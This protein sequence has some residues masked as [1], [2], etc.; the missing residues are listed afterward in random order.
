MTDS[1][2]LT[3]SL[4]GNP[5]TAGSIVLIGNSNVG[6]TTIFRKLCNKN[7]QIENLPDSFVEL[8]IGKLDLNDRLYKVIDI[9]GITSLFGYSEEE[10][11]ARNLIFS[12]ENVLI[13]QV[14][15]A[16]NL[17]RDLTLSC[18]LVELGKPM[19]L[20]LNMMDE[21][22]QKGIIID[23]KA[24]GDSLGID[25]VMTIGN[26]G[27]GIDEVKKSLID[28]RVSKI[29]NSYPA[30][31]EN[32]IEEI[33]SLPHRNGF[34]NRAFVL[35]LLVKESSIREYIESTFLDSH[36]M[37]RANQIVAQVNKGSNQDLQFS[38]VQR[39]VERAIEIENSCIKS[40]PVQTTSFG[41][42][43]SN[44][45]CHPV[46]GAPILLAVIGIL[47]LFVGKL[48]AG[49]F[50]D[51]IQFQIFGHYV[52]PF[53]EK[54]L[55]NI[56]S[57]LIQDAFLGTYGLISMGLTAGLG[58]VFPIICTFFFSYSILEDS[59]YL[60]R[61]GILLDSVFKRIGLNGKAVLPL[62]LGFSCVTMATLSAR[63]LDTKKERIIAIL[64]LWLCVPCSAQ[65]S[66][67]AAILASISLKAVLVIIG[68]VAIQL[69]IV[70]FTAGKL[71]PGEKPIFLM[72]IHPIRMPNIRFTLYKT[73]LKVKR[74]FREVIP[75]FLVASLVLFILDKTKVL[76][77]IEKAGEPVVTG[78]LGLP[79]KITEVFMLGLIRR[80]AGA[81]F[82]KTIAD[83]ERLSE[84]QII[85]AMVV[86]TLFVPCVTSIL[87][88]VKE[89]SLKIA[90]GISAFVI[91]YALL[92]G[93][94][95]NKLLH[96][97][98]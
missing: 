4:V 51:F 7:I 39:R 27:E 71:I 66:I 26:E 53:V 3:I 31:I 59:G 63:A 92:V 17:R 13:L 67:F 60:S 55:S 49:I 74:F 72:E 45:A 33:Q 11:I 78:L 40:L 70:G 57:R 83:A 81:A 46:Y 24:I 54:A 87:V 96:L 8:S 48:G 58:V 21:A 73:V 75:L 28:P 35:Q 10:L 84:I 95:L 69:L 90:G 1:Q 65:L 2:L 19:V 23:E 52:I 25:A 34:L 86:M 38:I 85:V 32:G 56:P 62:F 64:L 80:E 94:I 89:Y 47:Y 36:E 88:V 9:P 16:K 68:V 6:K 42:K 15:D 98:Y 44:C 43:F 37:E 91:G 79:P 22:L 50:A 5:E 77:F 14:A 97:F 93:I 61:I 82:F 76:H 29:R 30:Y 41:D 20:I 12:E 18:E